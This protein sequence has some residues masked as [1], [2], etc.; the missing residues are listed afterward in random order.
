MKT[1]KRIF[2][3][4]LA[5]V[6]L[7]S[8]FACINNGSTV[9]ETPAPTVEA[10]AETPKPTEAPTPEPT[11]APTPTPEPTEVPPQQGDLDEAFLAYDND[12]FVWYVSSDI[13]TLDQFCRHPENFG[14]DEASVE[15]TL[16]DFTEEANNEWVDACVEWR[17]KLLA[18][19]RELLSDRLQYAYDNYLRFFDGE[20]E[21]REWF[22]NYE[23]LDIYVG[24]QSNLPLEFGLYMFYDEKDVEN[25]MTLLADVPRYMEQVLAFEQERANRGWFMT[26]DALDQIL[27][28]L[29]NV[30]K[31]GKSSFLHS[32]FKEA[33][34]KA[35]FL[36]EEQKQA[37]IKQNDELVNTAWVQGYKLLYDGLKK[38]RPQCREAVGAYQQGGEAYAYFC[39]KLKHDGNNN[40]SVQETLTFL[41][42][43]IRSLYNQLYDCL[44][45]S[46]DKFTGGGSTALSSGSLGGD[47]SY[48]KL[49]MPKIVP[50]MPEVEVKYVEVPKEL[51]DGFSPAA[52]LTPAVDDYQ[53]NIILTNPKDKEH[54]TMSTLAHEG[55]PG[56]MYQFTY[57]YA[58][59]TIPKFL[60]VIESNGYAE[61]WSEN[62]EFN[63]ALINERYGA[64]YATAVFLNEVVTN[65]LIMYCSLLINGQGASKQDVRSYLQMWNMDSYTDTIYDLCITMPIYYVKYV[66]GFMEQY[67]LTERCKTKL[68]ENYD[69]IAF[70]TEYLSWG[71]GKFDL[72]N[73]RIDAWVNAQ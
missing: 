7:A 2:V 10:Q 65:S 46:Y 8:C 40:R 22:Y 71:P 66:V 23:P 16:G 1:F 6:M 30:A 63:I 41:D 18:I 11:E 67:E 45:A 33:M 5:A 70:Y 73:E 48:L 62:A 4:F 52:Y 43:N 17:E 69:S 14:I 20:I 42:K 36:T 53:H 37:Y 28:D 64:D 26:E 25:Y 54:Y 58:L 57:Q 31:S 44:M 9:K 38:L 60:M 59:G 34:E 13:T 24:L 15:V 3:F 27:T 56:H 12:L 49:L 21:S 35:D 39:W 29:D 72:L 61:A 68:G 51:Q 55:Y 47:E 19:D 32:T 50:P